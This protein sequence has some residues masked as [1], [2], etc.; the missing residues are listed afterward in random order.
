M[1]FTL[2]KGKFKPEAGIPDGDSVRFEADNPKLWDKL[3]GRPV[4]FG[5]GPKTKGTVQ[6]RFEGIDSIEKGAIQPLS[7]DSR[8]NM[9]ALINYVAATN[10][11]PT[12]YILARMTDD[13]TRRPIC[14]IFSGTTNLQD[15]AN[16]F[17]DKVLLRDSVNYKQMQAGFAYPLYYNTLF[18]SLREEFNQALLYAKQKPSGYWKTDATMSGVTVSNKNDLKTI[19]P[20]WPKIWR[21]LEEYFRKEN[22]LDNFKL[23]LEKK[24]ERIDVL[25]IMEERGLQDIVEVKGDTVRMTEPPENLRVVGK[26]GSRRR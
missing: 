1:P 6:L 4:A 11:E 26:A 24:N 14:F 22:S 8:D 2:I 5:A 15:G 18:T 13:K 3:E 19:P 12:G 17:L 16:V 21:R 10:E 9:L 25:S 23:F 20:I 7:T